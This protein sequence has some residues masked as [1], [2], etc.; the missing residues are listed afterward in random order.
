M[1][2]GA[3]AVPAT[4]VSRHVSAGRAD[5][6]K[7]GPPPPRKQ[8]STGSGHAAESGCVIAMG[9]RARALAMPRPQSRR[10]GWLPSS[11][12]S[13]RVRAL[14]SPARNNACEAG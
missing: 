4:A 7:R 10:A 6:V 11:S 5:A 14:P 8:A 1:R 2:A 13:R 12:G 9:R 3:Q